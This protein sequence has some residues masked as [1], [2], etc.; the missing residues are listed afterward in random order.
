MAERR[1]LTEGLKSPT[2][3]ADP[4]KE[5]EFVFGAKAPVGIVPNRKSGT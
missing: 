1:P 4:G 3:P 5:K 2:P